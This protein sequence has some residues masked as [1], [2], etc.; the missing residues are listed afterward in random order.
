MEQKLLLVANNGG[1]LLQLRHLMDVWKDYDRLWVTGDKQDATWLLCGEKVV[2]GHFPTDRNL[3]NLVRNF[4]LALR[5]M[6]KNKPNWVISTG[7]GMA[8]P[9]CFAAKL[10]GKKIMY[11]ESFAKI[12][13]PTISGKIVYP[14]ADVFLIQW[15]ELRSVYPKAKYVGTVYDDIFDSGTA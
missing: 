13:S 3:F 15:K 11:I 8:V 1:H 14:I 6:V 2:N 10:F 9:F 7:A 12:T 5:L 4:I